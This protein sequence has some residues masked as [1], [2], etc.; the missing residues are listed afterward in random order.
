MELGPATRHGITH[1]NIECT[2]ETTVCVVSKVGAKN[3]ATHNTLKIYYSHTS[4]DT[5]CH[6]GSTAGVLIH[7][8]GS[9][10]ETEAS[11]LESVNKDAKNYSSGR[12]GLYRRVSK[13]AV[14]T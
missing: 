5:P 10:Y 6:K 9:H 14:K 1:G 8:V 12:H 13:V 2:V 7:N 4:C 11:S 3:T